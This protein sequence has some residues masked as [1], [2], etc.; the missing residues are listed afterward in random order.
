MPDLPSTDAP[1]EVGVAHLENGKVIEVE[2]V[3]TLDEAERIT[4]TC[5]PDS[6]GVTCFVVRRPLHAEWQIH[7]GKDK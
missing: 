1:W 7:P 5:G 6:T 3:P 4:R 2:Q